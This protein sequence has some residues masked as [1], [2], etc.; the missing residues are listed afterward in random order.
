M[1]AGFDNDGEVFAGHVIAV[2]VSN[3]GEFQDTNILGVSHN[4]I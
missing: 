4:L 1:S 3:A 2:A